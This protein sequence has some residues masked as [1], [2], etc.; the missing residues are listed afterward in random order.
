MEVIFTLAHYKYNL[1]CSDEDDDPEL[2]L[3]WCAKL[4]PS[5]EGIQVSI[6]QANR[7][8]LKEKTYLCIIYLN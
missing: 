2:A 1:F 4:G 3:K 5:C 8:K 7:N 6:Q